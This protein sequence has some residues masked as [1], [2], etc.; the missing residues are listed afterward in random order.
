MLRI[1]V[2]ITTLVAVTL[3]PAATLA[4]WEV[5]LAGGG[6]YSQDEEV[7]IEY[8]PESATDKGDFDGSF[9]VLGQVG[10][11]FESAPPIGL[12]FGCSYYTS[13]GDDWIGG[14][15]GGKF[16]YDFDVYPI[17]IL[18]TARLPFL[19]DDAFPHGR[20]QPTLAVGP[21]IFI[22]DGDYVVEG[23][24]YNDVAVDGG[25][26]LRSGFAY[27]ITEELWLTLD[28]RF[29]YFKPESTTGGT[30]AETRAIGHHMLGG[31][32]VRF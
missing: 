7:T 18:A 9:T 31:V 27:G 29:T 12:A 5:R 16:E 32:S 23:V 28:Y 13:D 21:G 8:G 10:Y 19:K 3:L 2:I 1:C 17:S 24:S 20:L 14:R 11:W 22:T 6:V 4:E 26:D 15:N 25:L 30:S